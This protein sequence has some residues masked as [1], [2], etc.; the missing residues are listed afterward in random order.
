M[1]QKSAIVVEGSFI[2]LEEGFI[3][4]RRVYKVGRW[5]FMHLEGV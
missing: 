2:K 5:F 3:D 4:Q 1:D